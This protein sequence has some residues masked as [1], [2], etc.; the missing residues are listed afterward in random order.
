MPPVK[1]KTTTYIIQLLRFL[2]K[3]KPSKNLNITNHVI[4]KVG[5]EKEIHKKNPLVKINK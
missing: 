4:K 5:F 2:R 1:S 3:N